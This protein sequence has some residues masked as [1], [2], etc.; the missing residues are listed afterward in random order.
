MPNH[1]T[2]YSPNPV[3]ETINTNFLSPATA[4][5]AGRG[6]VGNNAVIDSAN[7][8]SPNKASPR[9]GRLRGISP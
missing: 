6:S 3:R 5:N 9:L 8:T 2:P 7:L 1:N 4:A